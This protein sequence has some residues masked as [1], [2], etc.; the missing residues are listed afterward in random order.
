MGDPVQEGGID[1]RL[2]AW[3]LLLLCSPVAAVLVLAWG[4]YV[5]GNGLGAGALALG[6]LPL[7][8]LLLPRALGYPNRKLIGLLLGIGLLDLG[9][10][11]FR[12]REVQEDPQWRFC[13]DGVCP[14]SLPLLARLVREDETAYA[15]MALSYGLGLLSPEE[16]AVIGPATQ[17]VYAGLG[18]RRGGKPGVNAVLLSSDGG[19]VE[20]LV[21]V[22]PAEA[23]VP[24]LIFLHGFGGLLTPFVDT[25]AEGE[26]GQTYAVVAPALDMSG[27]WWEPAGR[28]VLK[29]TLERLPEG[30]DRNRLWLVGLSNGAIGASHLGADP[31]LGP[32]FRGVILI[33]GGDLLRAGEQMTRPVLLL[34]GRSDERFPL[35][36]LE[37]VA[38]QLQEAGVNTTYK[39]LE[40]DHFVLFTHPERV[41]EAI[42]DWLREKGEVPGPDRGPL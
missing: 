32:L 6:S 33:V 13:V 8:L 18:Q 27:Y 19:R 11:A 30:V 3:F 41:R 31:E 34:P 26:L 2:V 23:P 16:Q 21:W 38:T 28:A 37:K 14:A 22:P 24:A 1:R 25:L 40:G 10:A 39:P 36:H 35:G 42:R 5:A 29:R 17:Q 12:V 20:E 7:L 15:G 4:Y 9:Y